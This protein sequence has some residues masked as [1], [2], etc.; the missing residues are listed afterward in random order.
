MKMG[1][2]SILKNLSLLVLLLFY[3]CKKP[4]EVSN[5]GDYTKFVNPFIGTTGTGHTFPGA[6]TPFGFIQVSPR[7]GNTTWEYCAGYQYEDTLVYGFAH[8]HLN[9]GGVPALGDILILPISNQETL[10]NEKTSFS[11]AKEAAS[12]GYY[13]TYL[14]E[15]K[16]KVELSATEHTGIQKYSFE[17]GGKNQVL[18]NVDDVLFAWGDPNESR[19]QEAEL[20]VENEMTLSGFLETNVKVKRKSFF[21][22]QFS[23]PFMDSRFLEGSK[24]RK[25]VVDYQMGSGEY[26]EV[27][28]A[29]STVSIEG[30][31]KNLEAESNGQTFG[32][33]RRNADSLWNSCLSKIT[34]EGTDEQKENFYTSIYRVFIQP[35]NIADVDGKYRGADDQIYTSPNGKFYSTFAF[36]DTYRAAHPLYTIL[37]P[38]KIGLFVDAAMA[39]YDQKGYLPVWPLW[40]RDSYSMIG[41][42]SVPVIV[43]AYLK[44]LPGIDA[45][46][47]F[48]AIKS[49]L[50]GNLS[51]KYNWTLYDKYGFLP[52]DTIKSEAVSR[53][54]EAT[55][56]DW[57]AAQMAKA[58]G[59]DE[60]YDFFI[61]RA[62][63]Y[64][65][66]FDPETKLM[67]GRNRDSSWVEPFNPY[68]VSHHHRS[69]GD[70]TEMNGWQYSWHV[71]H[72]VDGLIELM[73]GKEHFTTML[74]SLF[75]MKEPLQGDEGAMNNVTGL[76]GQYAH[77]NE[78]C[79]HIAYMY[80]YVNQPEKTQKYVT[81]IKRKFYKNTPDGLCGND[82]FGQMSAW[83][84]LN[85]LGFYPVNP[86]SGV[87]DLG[88]PS[89][90]YASINVGNNKTF[91]IKAENLSADNTY[92]QSVK[93]N[94]ESLENTQITY[95]QIMEGGVLEFSMTN[96][97]K[98]YSYEQ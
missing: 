48:A 95:K 31:K 92:V 33:I 39:H 19:V 83:Y 41:N 86:A 47:A 84:M 38:E 14:T 90:S 60:D 11:K 43:D 63:Y 73:G 9:G 20:V 17:K 59:K 54:L 13:T 57:C 21:T 64:K 34:I 49:T 50:T 88:S 96:K 56:D 82:D 69:P 8:N 65:N 2:L 68:K 62:N 76:I 3:A 81:E 85:A 58:L 46:K 67:R 7:T 44:G 29:I 79:H 55:F 6:T 30:A 36:W 26:L 89:F 51:K 97:S 1:Q 45:A 15:D 77:G 61:N 10:Q 70:Y 27:R 91:T 93:L 18:I 24:K 72:D 71:Q 35:N 22:I 98:L 80:N 25:L 12:P 75:T 53:T 23:K 4:S 94:G 52:S 42:H 78:P 37:I 40:A 5:L 74:D 28:V 32:E 87:F 16:I 66:V